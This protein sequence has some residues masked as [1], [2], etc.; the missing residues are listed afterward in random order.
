M[1]SLPEN[2][3]GESVFGFEYQ[4]EWEYENGFYITSHPTRLAKS[5]A[6]WELYKKIVDLP[7]EILEFGV[8]KGASLIRFATFREILEYNFSR[9]IIGFDAFGEFPKAETKDD[10]DFIINFET[11]S[12]KGIP[13]EELQKALSKK[14]F[15]NIELIEGNICD[16][17]PA[18]LKANPQLKAALM[19]ID[20]D[21]YAPTKCCLEYL[22]D[23]IVTGGVIIF[24]DYAS[25]SG[26][27]KAVDEFFA[28][29]NIKTEIKKTPY[30]SVPCYIVKA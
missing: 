16:T 8:F 11:V 21:V 22:Y 24:D 12:G 27:T 2:V 13:K 15:G 17:L 26:E 30:Y 25:V 18:Y 14:G 5:I 23:R 10:T 19:H 4:K 1:P 6:H 20:V 9:K 3:F 7:G 28:A 29:K